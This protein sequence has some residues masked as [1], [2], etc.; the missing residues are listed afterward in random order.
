MAR[1]G[2]Q[3]RSSVFCY[4][5]RESE[6]HLKGKNR[7]YELFKK[8]GFEVYKEVP[9]QERLDDGDVKNFIF[10]VLV[11]GKFVNSKCPIITILEVDGRKGHRTGITDNKARVRDSHFMNK[12]SIPTVR[13]AFEDLHGVNKIDDEL[14]IREVEYWIKQ[15]MDKIVDQDKKLYSKKSRCCKCGHFS[16]VHTFSGCMSCSCEFG[17][18]HELQ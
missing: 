6:K 13:F 3:P 12:Y 1:T 14:I 7:L 15:D 2:R 11:I 8:Y 17:F 9:S 4:Q 5:I 18:I 10:D 16:N